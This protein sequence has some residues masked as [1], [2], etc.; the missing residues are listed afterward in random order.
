MPVDVRVAIT[1]AYE[2]IMMLAARPGTTP[3]AARTWWT[4]AK[5]VGLARKVR[6]FTGLISIGAAQAA[7]GAR[8]VLE[9]FERLS[10]EITALVSRHLLQ[11]HNA[12]E[13]LAL[14][15]R[16][17]RVHL[18]LESEN[19][20]LAR[21]NGDY[22]AAGIELARF[23]TLSVERRAFLLAGPLAGGRICNRDEFMAGSA[24]VR[25]RRSLA[26]ET[27]STGFPAGTAEGECAPDATNLALLRACVEV[28]GRAGQIARWIGRMRPPEV[29][30]GYGSTEHA[31]LRGVVCRFQIMGTSGN[32]ECKILTYLISRDLEHLGRTSACAEDPRRTWLYIHLDKLPMAL[33]E[34]HER[35]TLAFLDHYPRFTR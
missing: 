28:A 2:E 29:R 6:R 17:E 34:L 32:R 27:T 10:R 20:A 11:G 13:F 1:N 4:S 33:A 14:I 8:L 31:N 35:A 5:G 15:E 21:L 16:C 9:H 12:D 7:P 3:A 30:I 26:P 18:V 22:V 23:D 25:R 24:T 19:Q